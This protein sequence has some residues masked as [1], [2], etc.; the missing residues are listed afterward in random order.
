[1]TKKY[2]YILGIALAIAI[3]IILVLVF[4]QEE[5]EGEEQKKS[6]ETEKVSEAGETQEAVN[7]TENFTIENRTLSTTGENQ[8]FILTPGYQLVLEGKE[9]DGSLER[10]VVTV[11]NDVKTIGKYET[12]IV[13][14]RETTKDTLTEVSR[15]F[16]A[17]DT[18]TK[19][20]FYFGKEVDVYEGGKV[21]SHEGAWSAGEANCKPG[22]MMPG[23][24]LLGARY[25]Q[26]IA[27][28]KAMDR[29][30]IIDNSVTLQTSAGTFK[31]CLKI[32]ESNPLEVGEET[33]GEAGEES[34]KKAEKEMVKK[35]GEKAGKEAV[36]EGEKESGKES[37]KEAG[38]KAK[39]ESGKEVIKGA[40][41]GTAE[42]AEKEYK[43]YAP[44]IGLIQDGDLL[45]VKYGFIKK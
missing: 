35:A 7:W 3:A 4:S 27:P 22:L 37:Q 24:I 10:L 32:A 1:M 2:Y 38:E 15:N 8:Y 14:E 19:D 36:E 34:G 44:K 20:V 26:E 45:L 43:I 41:E 6:E 23:T 28:G 29:A 9:E 21:V 39:K 30:E 13:E 31:G 42:G 33:A 25:Y 11:L 16:Y 40:A 12:R 18:S 5:E 17:I